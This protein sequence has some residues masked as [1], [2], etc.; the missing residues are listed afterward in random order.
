MII[1]RAPDGANK[2]HVKKTYLH[3]CEGRA[4][5]CDKGSRGGFDTSRSQHTS[6][7]HL[8]WTEIWGRAFTSQVPRPSCNQV[9]WGTWLGIYLLRS[10]LGKG[11]KMN[12][13]DDNGAM[14]MILWWWW[15][16][17]CRPHPEPSWQVKMGAIWEEARATD[18]HQT[19]MRLVKIAMKWEWDRLRC[20][21]K[22]NEMV[23]WDII[24]V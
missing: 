21:W 20:Q 16:F 4:V 8:Y 9:S 11:C 22:E 10:F 18:F 2:Y 12:D 17:T 24:E 19:A 1:T 3:N 13:D 7:N 14:A 23:D 6:R 15:S 5:V